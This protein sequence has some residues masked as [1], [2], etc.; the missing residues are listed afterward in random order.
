[1]PGVDNLDLG[2]HCFEYHRPE[3]RK[4]VA[5]GSTI[6]Y[7]DRTSAHSDSEL[8][9]DSVA[10]GGF[11]SGSS[12]EDAV[13]A[14]QGAGVQ[15]VIAK[16]FAFICKSSTEIYV[17]G[18]ILAN[19]SSDH[20]NQ[21]NMGLFNV[22]LSDEEFYAHAAEGKAI[23]IDKAAKTIVVEGCSTMFRYE[24][25]Q[26]EEELLNAGGILPLYKLHGRNVFTE[27]VKSRQG[28][29]KEAPQAKLID[30]LCENDTGRDKVD[31]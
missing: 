2:S 11:G 28:N 1:M 25:A 12:R 9:A 4:K 23:T 19:K 30:G 7:L 3:F 27:I 20:R 16:S 8:T 21:L 24:Q 17:S 31:W 18:I 26:I 13:R 22:T 14:L 15:A 6:M 29:A 10:E 5:E